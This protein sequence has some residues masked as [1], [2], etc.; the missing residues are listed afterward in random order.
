MAP[1]KRRSSSFSE[2][3]AASRLL[4]ELGSCPV[5]DRETEHELAVAY[6]KT[7]RPDLADR[8][9]RA[10]LR[11]VVKLA[12]EYATSAQLLGELVQE[13]C[14]G[15]VIAVKRFEPERGVRLCSYAS[16]WIRAQILRYLAENA[17]LVNMSRTRQGRE[18]FFRGELPAAEVSLDAE[19]GD[20]GRT[21]TLLDRLSGP[22]ETR[23]DVRVEEADLRRQL[24]DW[25]GQARTSRADAR[26]AAIVSERWLAEEPK[27]LVEIAERFA[28]TKERMR[29]IELRLMHRLRDRAVSGAAA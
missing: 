10:N 11:L 25:I 3:T 2:R 28:V 16:W 18:M 12:A 17:R 13:G 20:D 8:L 4:D 29:Q 7:G 27:T 14:V 15:L 23:P 6:Q 22:E 21:M 26:E 24:G 19:I 1:P 5:L 9:V